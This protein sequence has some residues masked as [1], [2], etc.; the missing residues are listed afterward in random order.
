MPQLRRT[1]RICTYCSSL[2]SYRIEK[3]IPLLSSLVCCIKPFP[4]IIFG[5]DDDTPEQFEATIKFLMKN[6]IGNAYFWILTPLPG[7][8]LYNE[9]ER[10]GRILIKDW[11]RYNLSD[12]VFQP[13]NFTPEELY[14]GYWNAFQQFFSLKNIAQRL[15]YNVPITKKPI[16]A[17]FRSLYYQLY[18][19]NKVN[20]Y[21]H[22]LSG[23]I[24]K[25]S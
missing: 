2:L 25:I 1:K 17:F 24:H 23:G 13:K 19:R 21:D 10:E 5:L 22:P 6:K 9:M 20:S 14:S 8:E 7:T 4:S 11:S 18:Y 12:V 3:A 16:D 15:F